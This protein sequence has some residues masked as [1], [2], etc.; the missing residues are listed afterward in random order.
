VEHAYARSPALRGHVRIDRIL[1]AVTF[2]P[3]ARNVVAWAVSLAAP[4]D[5]E[6]R[7]FHVLG[8]CGASAAADAGY[9]RTLSNLLALADGMP[10]RIRLS[11]G[12]TEGDPAAEILRHARMIHAD[13]IAIGAQADDH[14][15]RR[16]MTALAIA[17]PCPVVAVGDRIVIAVNGRLAPRAADDDVCRLVRAAGTDVTLLQVRP[18]R[19]SSH[20]GVHDMTNGS[21]FRPRPWTTSFLR[22]VR[23]VAEG[24]LVVLGFAAAILLIGSPVAL[25]VRVLHEGVSLIAALARWG[26]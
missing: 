7:L 8:D 9:D 6:V 19:R 10:G 22:V 21:A 23:A 17:A 25:L 24:S 1:C 16:M 3:S 20:S 26:P 2:S 5:S 13:L 11:A 12:V 4:H 14:R 18:E 15:A